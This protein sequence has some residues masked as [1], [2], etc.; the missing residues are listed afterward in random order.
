MI[1]VNQN[2]LKIHN[3]K[4]N[5]SLKKKIICKLTVNKIIQKQKQKKKQKQKR[6]YSYNLVYIQ[7]YQIL[8]IIKLKNKR[9]YLLVNQQLVEYL[10]SIKHQAN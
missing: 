2:Y 1:K 4:I 5:I 10:R 9:F 7:I 8:M 6:I 3:K